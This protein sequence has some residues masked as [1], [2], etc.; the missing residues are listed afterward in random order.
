M[1][2]LLVHPKSL[3]LMEIV[4]LPYIPITFFLSSQC[5]TLVAFLTILL[6]NKVPPILPSNCHLSFQL[7]NFISLYQEFALIYDN[8]SYRLPSRAQSWIS[9]VT[10]FSNAHNFLC[11]AL[12]DSTNIAQSMS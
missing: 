11:L 6:S 10:M 7:S 1:T 4:V 9:I 12:K 5:R 8:S 2:L 3:I